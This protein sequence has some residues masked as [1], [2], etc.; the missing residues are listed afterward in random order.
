MIIKVFIENESSSDQKNIFDEKTLEYSRSHKVSRKYPYPYGFILDSNSEDGGNIDCFV[1]TA[2]KLKSGEIV[3]CKP[4]GILEQFENSWDPK[5]Y[6]IEEIDH[7]ILAALSDEEVNIDDEVKGRLSDFIVHVFD[8][9][10]NK[11]VRVGNFL[12]ENFALKYLRK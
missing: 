4:I 5:K 7:N 6:G 1:I 8:H 11:K 12:D 2:K 10:P 3:E 9:L